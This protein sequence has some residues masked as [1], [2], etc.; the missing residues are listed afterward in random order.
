MSS[1]RMTSPMGVCAGPLSRFRTTALAIR[2]RWPMFPRLMPPAALKVNTAPE[3][4]LTALPARGHWFLESACSV[5]VTHSLSLP[6]ANKADA[7]PTSTVQ[8]RKLGRPWG[9]EL[10]HPTCTMS[11]LHRPCGPSRAAPSPTCRVTARLETQRSSRRHDRLPQMPP[12]TVPTKGAAGSRKI[13]R[14]PEWAGPV[15]GSLAAQ[16]TTPSLSSRHRK[17]TSC[18]LSTSPSTLP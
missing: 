10:M 17:H 9:S 8:T 4:P 13:Q 3:G 16:V 15:R 12:A 2:V 14:A 7:A 5:P 18:L 6:G 1:P 11:P